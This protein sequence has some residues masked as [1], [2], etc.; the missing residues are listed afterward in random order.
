MPVRFSSSRKLARARESTCTKGI[1]LL[2]AEENESQSR[3]VKDRRDG[4][5]CCSR[6]F[7]RDTWYTIRRG[8]ERKRESVLFVRVSVRE[9][10]KKKLRRS[11][12][13]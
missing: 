11:D 8:V 6:G 4:C 13:G 2:A 3:K 5:L 1:I 12:I 7:F 9:K 10:K